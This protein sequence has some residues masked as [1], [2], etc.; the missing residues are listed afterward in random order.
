MGAADPT[1]FYSAAVPCLTSYLGTL[2]ALA[3][4]GAIQRGLKIVGPVVLAYLAGLSALVLGSAWWFAHPPAAQMQAQSSLLSKC[5][6]AGHDW[7]AAAGGA[8]QSR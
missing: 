7:R 6:T 2:S 1:D 3:L 8:V 5:R 4:T